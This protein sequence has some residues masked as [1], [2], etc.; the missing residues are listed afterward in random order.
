M[1]EQAKAAGLACGLLTLT[2]RH[3]LGDDLL[4]QREVLQG[5]WARLRRGAPWRRFADRHGWV[6]EW[7]TLE[8][9]H[10]ASGWHAHLH[11]MVIAAELPA[12]G[13]EAYQWLQQRWRTCVQAE[14][15]QRELPT[16]MTPLR[17]VGCD[18][19]EHDDAGTYI[20]KLA[21][22][23][24]CEGGKVG[25]G[26]SPFELLA[27]AGD[28][29]ADAALWCEYAAAM[30]GAR[31]HVVSQGLRRWAEALPPMEAEDIGAEAL[32]AHARPAFWRK[33][34]RT[35]RA[36]WFAAADR[37]QRYWLDWLR[38]THGED[39]Y[40]EAIGDIAALASPIPELKRAI[41][42]MGA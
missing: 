13:G 3:Q 18:L 42:R 39:A 27:S 24:S 26:R 30:K 25:A 6:G 10:G 4:A 36:A 17:D 41:A 34:D 21:L 33:L 31:A 9:T 29:A 23:V 1:V 38:R 20:H 11:A 22:E 5:A 7:R 2:L 28:C 32:L 37:G 8:V 19:R 14:L 35:G 40:R 12:R 16:R 15:A